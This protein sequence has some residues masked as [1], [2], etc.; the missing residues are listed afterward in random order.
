MKIGFFEE[1]AGVK[2]WTRLISTLPIATG[3][4]IALLE[5][6]YAMWFNNAY[7]VHT[8]LIDSLVVGGFGAKVI[9]KIFAEKKQE[10]GNKEGG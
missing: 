3:C 8:G 5:I 9:Q 7:V 4:L 6:N 10:D 2:S 1:K